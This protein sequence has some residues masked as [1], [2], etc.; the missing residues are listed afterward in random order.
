MPSAARRHQHG[1]PNR[2]SLRVTRSRPCRDRSKQLVG[3]ARVLLPASHTATVTFE[4]HPSR[5]TFFDEHMRFVTEP[6]NFEFSIGGASDRAESTIVL[7]LTGDV[8]E[9]RQREIVTTAVTIE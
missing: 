1:T 9:Y 4:M 5:R 6:R 2:S 7:E 8:A 3:F